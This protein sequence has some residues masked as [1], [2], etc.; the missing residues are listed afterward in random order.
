MTEE[1]QQ[2]VESLTIALKNLK[3]I[4][5]IDEINQ[6]LSVT[7]KKV[8]DFKFEEDEIL[9]LLNEELEGLIAIGSVKAQ[10]LYDL[11]KQNDRKR[12][13]AEEMEEGLKRMDIAINEAECEAQSLEKE[14]EKMKTRE[15]SA[16]D[17]TDIENIL[18]LFKNLGVEVIMK[19]GKASKLIVG[20]EPHVQVFIIQNNTL[21]VEPLELWNILNKGVEPNHF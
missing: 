20:K 1:F 3:T 17:T 13:E 4:K 21:D 18:V 12:K 10:E 5:T 11:N 6:E 16:T 15:F 8:Q 19:E 2:K 7:V 9:E 14:I